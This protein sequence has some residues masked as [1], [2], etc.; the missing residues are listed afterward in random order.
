MALR[1]RISHAAPRDPWYVAA[2]G[3]IVA[4]GAVAVTTAWLFVVW[5]ATGGR[6]AGIQ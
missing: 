6:V 4:V 2:V 5:L 1:C 3:I